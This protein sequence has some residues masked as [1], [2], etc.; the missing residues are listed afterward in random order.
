VAAH[1]VAHNKGRR[2]PIAL[3]EAVFL[4]ASLSACGG[5][6]THT[7]KA[8]DTNVTLTPS[9]VRPFQPI[10]V[11]GTGYPPH[12]RI[13]FQVNGVIVPSRHRAT[14]SA[15]GA[16]TTTLKFP[17]SFKAA[18]HGRVQVFVTTNPRANTKHE[19]VGVLKFIR[20]RGA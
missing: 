9:L 16:F 4:L 12:R 5:S 14:T 11:T 8:Y 20:I 13:Y 7:P 10:T 6:G 1:V 3:F 17:T 2:A 19:I 15:A 18:L